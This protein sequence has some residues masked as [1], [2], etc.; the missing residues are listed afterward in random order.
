MLVN[1]GEHSLYLDPLPTMFV[2]ISQEK[3]AWWTGRGEEL[4]KVDQL[5][6]ILVSLFQS[7]FLDLIIFS[8]LGVPDELMETGRKVASNTGPV[9]RGGGFYFMR[10]NVVN[11]CILTQVG[12]H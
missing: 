6:P 7:W 8:V 2:D 4:R 5:P 12:D 3:W 9:Y 1:L 10:G 11:V